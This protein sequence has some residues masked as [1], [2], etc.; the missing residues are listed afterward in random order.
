MNSVIVIY[1]LKA[2]LFGPGVYEAVLEMSP[3]V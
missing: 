3:V 2:L 1:P